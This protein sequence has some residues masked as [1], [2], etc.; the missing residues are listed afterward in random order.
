MSSRAAFL[1]FIVVLSGAVLLSGCLSPGLV[2]FPPARQVTSIQVNDG[3]VSDDPPQQT[4]KDPRKIAEILAFLHDKEGKWDRNSIAPDIGKYHVTFVGE[5][6]RLFLRTGNGALQVQGNDY[7]C[8]YKDLSEEEQDKLLR[9]LSID[10]VAAR[11]VS[12]RGSDDEPEL[13]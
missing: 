5:N 10:P 3:P 13:E 4:I 7:N 6:I 11:Q 9:L 12:D 1:P 2:T 8:H